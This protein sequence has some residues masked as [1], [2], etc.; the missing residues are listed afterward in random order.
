MQK[1]ESLQYNAA[2]AITGA[3]HDTST[4][5]IYEELGWESLTNRRW[6]RRLRLFFPLANNQA[7]FYLCKVI[8]PSVLLWRMNGNDNLFEWESFQKYIFEDYKV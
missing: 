2:L 6:Y 8:S 7:P 3:W 5:R 1:L 4:D